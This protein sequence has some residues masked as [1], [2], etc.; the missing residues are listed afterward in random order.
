[1]A[2][3]DLGYKVSRMIENAYENFGGD[4]A[5]FEDI[6]THVDPSYPRKQTDK[7]IRNTLLQQGALHKEPRR[8]K[9]GQERVLIW[10]L[11]DQSKYREGLHQRSFLRL[12]TSNRW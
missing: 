2:M 6:Q 12:G 10:I 9:P 4:M 11:R 3:T 7:A 8:P 5:K 1:M